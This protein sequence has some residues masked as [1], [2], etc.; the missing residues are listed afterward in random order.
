MVYPDS[1]LKKMAGKVFSESCRIGPSSID[2]TLGDRFARLEPRYG[3]IDLKQ[4]VE[5]VSEVSERYTL[6][7]RG[8]ILAT[9]AEW[10]DIPDNVCGFVSGRSSIGRLGLQVQN[11]G[12]IDAGFRG[13]IT[14][15]LANQTQF[16]IVL[17]AGVR[18]CQLVFFKQIKRSKR[19]YSGKYL[20]Q[21]G[22]VGSRIHED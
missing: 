13:Q 8:F 6:P 9:T 20:N 18:V 16:P 3:G 14:L 2:L 17:H 19:P 11:A 12:F 15:E 4:G 10:V 5:Y 1:Q 21:I 7:P 22:A